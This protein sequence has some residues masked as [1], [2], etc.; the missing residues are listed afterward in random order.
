MAENCKGI[1]GHIPSL[2]GIFMWNSRPPFA[3]PMRMI[4]K[5]LSIA[6]YHLSLLKSSKD[7]NAERKDS[8]MSG[9]V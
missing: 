3:Q 9:W 7:S 8:H 6:F 1:P 4:S 5:K 2:V